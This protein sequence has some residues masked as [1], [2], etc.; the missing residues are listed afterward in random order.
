MKKD[1]SVWNTVQKLAHERT[2]LDT[3][4]FREKEVWWCML[5]ANMGFE[6]DGKGS[7]TQRPVLIIRKLNR[8]DAIAIPLTRKHAKNR[9]YSVYFKSFDGIKRLALISQIRRIDARRL[10]KKMFTLDDNNYLAI[11]KAVTEM[12]Q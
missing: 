4:F 11:K 3:L 7:C 6:M 12:I 5:G 9:K 8:Y 10:I 1:F 2:D